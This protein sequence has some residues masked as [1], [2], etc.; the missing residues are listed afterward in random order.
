MRSASRRANTDLGIGKEARKRKRAFLDKKRMASF[1]DNIH[2]NCET[3]TDSER[4]D[5]RRTTG[6]RDSEKEA[7]R[8]GKTRELLC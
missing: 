5:R 6:S 8:R 3:E 7:W 1:T 2:G 4:D